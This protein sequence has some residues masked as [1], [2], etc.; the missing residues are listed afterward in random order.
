MRLSAWLLTVFVVAFPHS[1]RSEGDLVRKARSSFFNRMP[2]DSSVLDWSDRVRPCWVSEGR[3]V[4]TVV[5]LVEGTP[6]I[7]DRHQ[8]GARVAR[9]LLARVIYRGPLWLT[10]GIADTMGEDAA[11]GR[12]AGRRR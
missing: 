6:G 5:P 8:I 4:E 1:A 9:G 12:G 3:K 11:G 10:E 7:D 2:F